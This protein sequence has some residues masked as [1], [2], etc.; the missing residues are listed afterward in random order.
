MS[1][2]RITPEEIMKYNIFPSKSYFREGSYTLIEACK[3]GKVEKIMDLLKWNKYLV[4]DF[5]PVHQT[6]LHWAA[7]RNFPE[8]IKILLEHGAYID[9]KDGGRRTPL[10]I[11]SRLGHADCVEALLANGANPMI[12]TH[13][14]TSALDV[15]KTYEIK[16][17]LKKV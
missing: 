12:Q 14:G 11:A 15:A 7:K 10:F 2:R 1:F 13:I 3:K 9:C 8:I 5:D 4:Y 17:Y 16:A 6:A